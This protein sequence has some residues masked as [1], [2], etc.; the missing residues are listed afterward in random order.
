MIDDKLCCLHLFLSNFIFLECFPASQMISHHYSLIFW[1]LSMVSQSV[2]NFRGP[3]L[4]LKEASYTFQGCF[5]FT[6]LVP[7]VTVSG[8][9]A[10]LYHYF[11]AVDGSVIFLF[12]ADRICACL[13]H[14]SWVY[15]VMEYISEACKAQIVHFILEII[16]WIYL[17][18]NFAIMR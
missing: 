7:R 17:N 3:W 2:S 10:F 14:H 6:S 8:W 5:C 11:S 16:D 15:F 12:Q 4:H 13:C 1:H 18:V 9:Q